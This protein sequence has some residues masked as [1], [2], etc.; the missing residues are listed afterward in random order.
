MD[1]MQNNDNTLSSDWTAE[2]SAE[3]FDKF[4]IMQSLK[5][6]NTCWTINHLNNSSNYII[7]K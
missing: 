6:T 4:M 5:I 2:F 7:I 1:N 3:I